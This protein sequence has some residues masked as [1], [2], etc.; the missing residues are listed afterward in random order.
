MPRPPLTRELIHATF[1]D[2]TF[3]TNVWIRAA[4][5]AS[6]VVEPGGGPRVRRSPSDMTTLYFDLPAALRLA[7]HAAAAAEHS[8]SFTESEDGAACPGALLWVAD[9][10]VYL[11]SGGIPGLRVDPADDT[12]RHEVVYADGWGEDDL[13][14]DDRHH[15]DLGGDDF[16]EHLHLHEHYGARAAGTGSTLLQAMRAA[17]T[18]GYR[19]LVI[20]V[21]NEDTFTLRLSR[22]GPQ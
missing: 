16:V 2:L 4:A 14:S 1:P 19:Y 7:E 6:T 17:A 13:N 8:L 5:E 10:G 22:T 3:R 20:D 15:S 21:P 18:S 12:S 9:L 11:M